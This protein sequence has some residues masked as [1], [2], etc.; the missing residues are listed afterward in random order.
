[1]GFLWFEITWFQQTHSGVRNYISKSV[2]EMEHESSVFCNMG[3]A[4][5]R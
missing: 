3:K 5:Q 1:M 2:N 4:A